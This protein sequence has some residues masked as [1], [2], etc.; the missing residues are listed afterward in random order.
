MKGSLKISTKIGNKAIHSKI[1]THLKYE[2]PN[3]TMKENY[4]K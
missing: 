1:N 3:K 2:F 4:E